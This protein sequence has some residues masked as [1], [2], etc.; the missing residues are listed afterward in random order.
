MQGNREKNGKTFDRISKK[1]NMALRLVEFVEKLLIDTFDKNKPIF[2]KP[3]QKVKLLFRWI[4]VIHVNRDMLML[5]V[6]AHKH[7][8]VCSPN[9]LLSIIFS[10]PQS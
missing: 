1:S 4:L 5:L 2:K 6:A 8:L 10:A 3:D 9:S 7:R